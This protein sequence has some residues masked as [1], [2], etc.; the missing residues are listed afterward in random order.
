[1][2]PDSAFLSIWWKAGSPQRDLVVELVEQLARRGVRVIGGPGAALLL[3][4]IQRAVAPEP[5]IFDADE[6]LLLCDPRPIMWVLGDADTSLS[7]SEYDRVDSGGMTYLLHA[8][9]LM[10]PDKPTSRLIDVHS[11]NIS[12]DTALRSL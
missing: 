2:D 5:L 12:I 6:E 3:N 1:M 4:T 9:H 11:A 10:H 7:T 8:D